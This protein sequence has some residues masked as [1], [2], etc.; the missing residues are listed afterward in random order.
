MIEDGHV[1]LIL[2]NRS[3]MMQEYGNLGNS[4]RT[5]DLIKLYRAT[6]DKRSASH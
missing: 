5:L 6:V 3:H 1:T 2:N 4:M